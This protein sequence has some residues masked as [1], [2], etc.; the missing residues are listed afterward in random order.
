MN[1]HSKNLAP[2]AILLLLLFFNEINYAQNSL[3]LDSLI[4][5]DQWRE[6]GPYRGGRSAAVTGV[7]G[8]EGLYYF[9][10]TGGGVWK[11]TNAGKSWSNI[12]DG[13]FGGSIGAIAVSDSDKNVVFVGGG[14]KTVRGNVSSGYGIWKSV[15]AGDSWEF[16]GLGKSRHISRIRIHPTNHNIVYAAVMGNLY[17][18]HEERGLFKTTDGGHT[19]KKMLHVNDGVGFVDLVLDPNNPRIMFATSWK[20]RRNPFSLSSGGEGS[21][22][23]KSVDG[24]ETWIDLSSNQ[25]LPEGIWGISGVCVSPVNSKRIWA[26][27]EN[28][29]GGVYRSDDGGIQW[30]RIN[31][32]RSLRQRAW[33]YSRIYADTED[34]DI[35]YVLNVQYHKSKDGGKTFKGHR[36]PHGDHHDLWIDPNNHHHMIIGD[37]GGA[38][39]SHDDGDSWTTYHNQPTA[40]FYRVTTDN[41]VPYRIYAAQQD[42]STI[43]IAHRTT[44]GS[45]TD[46]DWERS[47]GG[48][49][50]H[51]AIDPMN[52][53]IVYGGSYGGYLTRL[54]HSTGSNRAINIWP[55]NPM[56]HGAEGMKYR[57]QW[58]FPVFF[59][60][61]NPKKLFACSNHLHMSTDEGQSWDILS[62][63]LTKND[64]NKLGVSGGPITKDNTGVEYY[65]TIFAADESPLKE[66]LIWVGSDDGLV[67]FTDNG[68]SS[69]NNVTPKELP[70]WT[71]INCIEPDP[72]N[73]AGCYLA[74][75]SY[76]NGDFQP[77]LYRTD[78]YG[79]SWKKITNGIKS[80][81]F[82]RAIRVDPNKQGVLYV[83]TESGIYVSFN[84][85]ANWESLQFNLPIVP[86]TD[87]HIKENNLIA[88]TQGR[89]IWMLD[90]LALFH[91]LEPLKSS[92]KF[93]LFKPKDSYRM[94]GYQIK[95]PKIA[96][97]NHKEGVSFNFYMDELLDSDTVQFTI[98]DTH[99][100]LVRRYSNF[101]PEKQNK[102]EIK[103]GSNQFNWNLRYPSAKKFEGMILWWGSLSGPKALPGAYTAEISINDNIVATSFN[104][105]PDPRFPYNQKDVEA[106]FDFLK[107]VNLKVSEAHQTIIDIRKIRDQIKIYKK[108]NSYSIEIN[109]LA[110]EI[111][112]I[113]TSIEENLYQTKNRSG[114]DPLNFPIKLTNK[115]AHLNSL[116]SLGDYPPTV[117]SL[118]LKVELEKK[119]DI[120]LNRFIKV[121]KEMIPV[122]NKK[123]KDSGVDPIKLEEK[124]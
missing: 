92:T 55:D 16:K 109:A 31:E 95:N 49:S 111:D 70:A 87:L 114:Q 103:P 10:S 39:V 80:E 26:I 116:T 33:Y 17:K 37:D 29:D 11:S 20:I 32:D 48:E 107:E 1:R 91:Q 117:Q 57:F 18:D 42:N 54:D 35:V 5:K 74:A 58:N 2:I 30:T 62:P 106:Q 75:T 123:I 53:D 98:R 52:N 47:A 21:G 34:E 61:H 64:S 14:E 97:L 76:K 40:Q 78:N 93:H 71:M 83:G 8:S 6:I 46:K 44:S 110:N 23:W 3:L 120:E 86:I 113:I 12:S 85:G 90:D 66:G 94:P 121:K 122:L 99:S 115:L 101:A 4:V 69:W 38:Q 84:D 59:S 50:A 19:W 45:I 82:T 72:F 68:G 112:S 25:G 79:K 118:A 73:I 15:D 67:H 96:G 7:K 24:G 36:A 124:Q 102:M 13:Y 100:N 77:L 88:A 22:L 104:I 119:I 108:G 65:C 28:K 9:G 56:G 105:L 60:K 89:G 43:R 63:D 81:H 27:I 41:H 51:I